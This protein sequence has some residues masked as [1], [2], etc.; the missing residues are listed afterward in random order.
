MRKIINIIAWALLIIGSSCSDYLDYKNNNR[1]AVPDKLEDLQALLDNFAIMNHNW[2]PSYLEAAGDDYFLTNEN[3]MAVHESQRP[4][5]LW[6]HIE[7]MFQNDWG[8]SYTVIYNANF[9]IDMLKKIDKHPSNAS[10]W[11]NI[12]GSALFFRAYSYLGLLWTYGSTYIPHGDNSSPAIVLREDSDFNKPSKLSSVGKGYEQVIRDVKEAIEYLPDLPI[13]KS[14]PS[15]AA[16][17]ALLARAYLSMSMFKEAREYAN[18]ALDLN[19][20]IMDY[21]NVEEVDVEAQQPFERFNKEVIFYTTMNNILRMHLP[22][23]AFIDSMLYKSYHTDDLRRKTFFSMDAD[24]A[25]LKSSFSQNLNFLFTGLTTT[26]A[27]FIKMETEARIGDYKE[28]LAW[29]NNFLRYRY[30]SDIAIQLTANS[31]DETL[32]FIL[33]E[34]RKELLMRGIRLSDVKRFALEDPSIMMRRVI[35][36]RLIELPPNSD[37]VVRNLPTD[38]EIYLK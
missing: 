5:Y 19:G 13:L 16:A 34:R 2:T 23:Y 30:K 1:L 31:R 7:Y 32:Q 15:K 35:E 38:I 27:L 18:Y 25:K 22:R 3:Y 17:S 29:L 4:V 26:E 20:A 12:Y 6:Q 24:R 36:D 14:R 21:N 28:T 37:N 10:D 9:C 8:K 11:D 33:S